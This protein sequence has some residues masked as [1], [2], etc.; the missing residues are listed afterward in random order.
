[1]KKL[2]V[3]IVNYNVK[4]FLEQA[5]RSVETA[6]KGIDAEVF[7]VDNNSVDGSVQMVRKRFPW[8]RLI[9]NKENLGFSKAN[10]QAIRQATGQYVLLL[11]PDTV[12]EEDT[13][14]KTLAFMDQHPEAGALGVQMVNG[15]GRFLPESKRSLPTPEVAFYKIFGLSKLFPKSK[16]FG[17]YHL[18]YLDPQ[19]N[20]E[21]EVLCGA[22]MLLRKSVLDQVGLLDEDYFMYGED[23][24]LSYRIV[25]AGYKNYYF[26]ETRIIHY[27]GESTKKGSLNYVLVFYNAML[28]FARKHFSHDGR[29][30][31]MMLIRLAIYF[32]AGLAI[33]RRVV[34]GAAFPFV[35]FAMVWAGA[36]GMNRLWRE[37]AHRPGESPLFDF[38]AAPLYALVFVMLF[39]I[40]GAYSRP[41]KIRN[42]AA[43]VAVGFMTIATIS[44]IFK[45]INFSRAVVALTSVFAL[46]S[47]LFVRGGVNFLH[48]GNFFLDHKSRRRTVIVGEGSEVARVVRLLDA[49][50]YYPCE[51]VGAVSVESESDA[52]FGLPRIGEF[53]QLDEI[54]R[55][56]G[57]DEVIFCNKNLSTAA[58]ITTMSRLKDRNLHF[59]IVPET[60]DY[61]VGPNVILTA[62]NLKPLVANLA[63]REYRYKKWAFDYALTIVMLCA[64]PLTFW[65]Y[66]KPFSALKN[67]A[68]VLFG[69][70]H[71]VGYIGGK[72][73]NLPKIKRGLLDMGEL[74]RNRRIGGPD[75]E[76]SRRL[77]LLY[78][79]TY[80]PALDWEIFI[81]GFRN[82]GA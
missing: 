64:Y 77:N 5:L 37:I 10:N 60:A 76:E 51:M 35:E 32:R 33:L 25:R 68:G 66:R 55:H 65:I 36:L 82:I 24:D 28:I 56:Y 49:Q 54:V 71:L 21:V 41:F 4:H 31:L 79:R 11:N 22:F 57:I 42:V 58:I 3:V 26:A 27:K 16:T 39:R 75:E 38:V 72:C 80:S 52:D 18:T 13:F 29:S 63:K 47:A 12:V 30:G 8:V 14:R 59:K 73:Q 74:F 43:A 67:L 61:L 50:I 46:M 78:A 70:Y 62:S 44:F 1:M 9:A 40:F 69:D 7:V 53:S 45:D 19:K 15:K 17:K 48:S 20:H 2:S 81:N 23:I 6:L 34:E